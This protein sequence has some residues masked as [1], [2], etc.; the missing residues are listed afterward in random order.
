VLS[1]RISLAVNLSDQKKIE[2]LSGFPDWA[3]LSIGIKYCFRRQRL[4]PLWGLVAIDAPL[5]LVFNRKPL[6]PSLTKS[7]SLKK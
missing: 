5:Q 4:A 6:R 2:L 7:A 3:V 1:A